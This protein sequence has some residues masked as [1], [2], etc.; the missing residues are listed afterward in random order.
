MREELFEKTPVP[1]AI[2]SLAL[3]TMLG[4]L[5]TIIYNLADTFFVGQTKDEFQVAAVTIVM[6]IFMILMAFGNVFGIGGGT[7]IS[8]L[9][10]QKRADEARNV[11][12]VATYLC[13]LVGLVLTAIMLIF[14]GPL[15][16]VSG[17]S[18]DTEAFTREY[19]MYIAIGAVFICLQQAMG[20]LVRAEGAAKSAVAGMMLGT[21][22][23]IV[24]DPFMILDFGLGL[25]VAGAGIATVLGC[26]SSVLFYTVYL[27]RGK[28]ALDIRFRYFK[29]CKEMLAN[30]LM[31]GIPVFLNNMLMSSANILLNNFA[32]GFSDYFLTGMG[33]ANRVFSIPIM[34]FIGLGQ[35]MQPFVGYNY[36]AGRFDRMKEAIRFTSVFSLIMGLFFAI[37]IF[38]GSETFIRAFID[39]PLVLPYGNAVLRAAMWITPIIGILF[40]FISVF[41]AMGKASQSL[42]LSI[43]RQGFIFIPMVIL[44]AKFFGETGL[45]WA[46]PVSD[47]LSLILCVAVYF[48]T[49]RKTERQQRLK[50]L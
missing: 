45:V 4:M 31:I 7:Y 30:I 11:C 3:P 47:V 21:V 26:F 1:K 5:V 44:G 49:I 46:Q 15:V 18:P 6:P 19:L 35:G 34:L 28:T 17:A 23:N 10:G 22:I 39:K 43:A 16:Q 38:F 25:G 9:L 24:L 14:M 29:P 42:F 37:C 20:Q 33:V 8:R 32:S 13:A 12:V 2:M 41:Q 40:V 27:L 48:P 50:Q 36:S